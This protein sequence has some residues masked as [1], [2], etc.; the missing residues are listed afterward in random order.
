MHP[1]SPTLR[2]QRHRRASSSILPL[3]ALSLPLPP[4][5][6]LNPL[7]PASPLVLALA[8]FTDAPRSPAVLLVDHLPPYVAFPRPSSGPIASLADRRSL[9][10]VSPRLAEAGFDE[11]TALGATLGFGALNFVMVRLLCRSATVSRSHGLEK[12]ELLTLFLPALLSLF[13]PCR[14]LP[15]SGPSTLSAG[16]SSS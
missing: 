14:L 12:V 4:T 2:Y 13:F 7:P 11:I 5:L 9:T 8:L 1:L 3:L 16:T 10:S 15:P 6:L